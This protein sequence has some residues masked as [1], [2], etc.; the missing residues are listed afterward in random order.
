MPQILLLILSQR[1][2]YLWPRRQPS[3][4]LHLGKSGD[5]LIAISTSGES[6][7]IIRAVARARS[8]DILTV[9]FLGGT[10]GR[11]ASLVDLAIIVPGHSTAHIQESHIAIGHI[12][13]ELIEEMLYGAYS[14]NRTGLC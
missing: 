9:G 6:P 11:L 12:L 4:N 8:K 5:A 10:G 2:I 13:C 3:H 7:N 14:P 1:C